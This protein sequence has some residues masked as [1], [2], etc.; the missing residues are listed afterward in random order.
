MIEL[1]GAIGRPHFGPLDCSANNSGVEKKKVAAA[2]SWLYT[3]YG[4]T[5]L[6]VVGRAA[7][8]RQTDVRMLSDDRLN[9]LSLNPDSAAIG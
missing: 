1:V 6:K 5:T 9:D 2:F 8:E 7:V 4:E 3:S